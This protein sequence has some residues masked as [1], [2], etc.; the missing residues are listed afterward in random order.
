MLKKFAHTKKPP[1]HKKYFNDWITQKS[2]DKKKIYSLKN[3]MLKLFEKNLT[4]KK[5]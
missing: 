3:C 2:F 4:V 5:V 1:R